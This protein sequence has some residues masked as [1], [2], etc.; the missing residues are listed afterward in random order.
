MENNVCLKEL[1]WSPRAGRGP[2]TGTA[3]SAEGASGAGTRNT[4][5]YLGRL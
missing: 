5:S 3:Q 4:H 2:P 1:G